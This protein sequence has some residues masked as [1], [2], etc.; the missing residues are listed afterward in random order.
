MILTDLLKN[1]TNR[2]KRNLDGI[3][4]RQVYCPSY[5]SDEEMSVYKEIVRK[6][7]EKYPLGS[8]SLHINYRPDPVGERIKWYLN[9]DSKRV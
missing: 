4:P 7:Y 5:F 1:H 3:I 9:L 2:I 6:F 8:T